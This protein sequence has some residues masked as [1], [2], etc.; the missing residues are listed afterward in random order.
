MSFIDSVKKKFLGDDSQ[1]Q[2][3]PAGGRRIGSMGKAYTGSGGS[4]VSSSKGTGFDASTYSPDAKPRGKV[5]SLNEFNPNRSGS[6]KASGKGYAGKALDYGVSKAKAGV[7]W[8]QER[9]MELEK[10]NKKRSGRAPRGSQPPGYDGSYDMFGVGGFGDGGGGGQWQT[11]GTIISGGEAYEEVVP[12]RRKSR[13]RP[14][15]QERNE[16]M[17]P[18]HIPDYLRHMF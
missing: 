10:Q 16:M 15:K 13:R 5:G 9:G 8:M 12:R 4:Y 11:Q 6:S 7:G 17:E 2:K 14:A 1:V 18:G 3:A